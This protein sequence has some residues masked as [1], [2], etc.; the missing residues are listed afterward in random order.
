MLA[1]ASSREKLS[2]LGE[3]A[4]NEVLA[5]H[6]GQRMALQYTTLYREMSR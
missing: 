3:A 1:L 6:S 4:R 2:Q 5:H